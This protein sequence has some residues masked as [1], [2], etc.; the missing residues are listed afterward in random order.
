MMTSESRRPPYKPKD[1]TIL[2]PRSLY[3]RLAICRSVK[4]HRF[5]DMQTLHRF[6]QVAPY[7]F[8]RYSTLHP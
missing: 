5:R 2:D 3:R 8:H 6:S 4:I 1:A 7:E